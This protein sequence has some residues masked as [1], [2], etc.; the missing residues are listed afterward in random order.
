MES[1]ESQESVAAIEAK[2]KPIIARVLKLPI[3]KVQNHARFREDLGVD[4]LDL[5]LLL[6]EIEDQM[7]IALTDDDAKKIL[8]VNDAIRLAGQFLPR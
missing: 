5:V 6:Y 7:G 8:T 4:S 3:E 2:L 1:Q